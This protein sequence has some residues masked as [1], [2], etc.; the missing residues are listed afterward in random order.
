VPND[1]TPI[2]RTNGAQL[3]TDNMINLQSAARAQALATE[4]GQG[5]MVDVRDAVRFG[6]KPG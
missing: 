6:A 1:V 3:E 5:R 4:P 2:F